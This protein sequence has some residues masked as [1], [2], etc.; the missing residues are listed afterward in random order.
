M[1]MILITYNVSIE[2]EIIEALP[3]LGLHCFTQWP[4]VLGQGQSTGARFDS[5]VWPGANGMLMAVVEDG[6]ARA[7]MAGLEHM[8]MTVAKRD[9]LKAFLLN[10]EG[11]TGGV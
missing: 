7:A 4:R 3:G 11:V 2:S 6:T 1:K 8:R 10:V 9:G 5:A